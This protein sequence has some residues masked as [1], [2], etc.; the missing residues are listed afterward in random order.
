MGVPDP[1]RCGAR[2]LE[3]GL[4]GPRVRVIPQEAGRHNPKAVWPAVGQTEVRALVR[5]SVGP[6]VL[7]QFAFKSRWW[8]R[9][10]CPFSHP[11]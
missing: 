7:A 3:K 6:K 4:S 9:F 8:L 10:P 1:Q 2:P 5:G 11:E